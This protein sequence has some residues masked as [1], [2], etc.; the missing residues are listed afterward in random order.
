M[1]VRW[2]MVPEQ[3]YVRQWCGD[4]KTL[5]VQKASSRSWK[6][7]TRRWENEA[8]VEGASWQTVLVF[9]VAR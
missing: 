4:V 6:K 9:P 7:I 3:R 5:V 8:L 2:D 1:P